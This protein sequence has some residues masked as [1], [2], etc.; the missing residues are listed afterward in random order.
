LNSISEYQFV[1]DFGITPF[2][3]QMKSIKVVEMKNE[4]RL[5]VLSNNDSLRSYSFEK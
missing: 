4:K 3:E 1:S 5:L 2:S